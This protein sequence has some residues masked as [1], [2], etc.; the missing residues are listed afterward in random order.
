MSAKTET[1]E[2]YEVVIGLEIHVELLTKSKMFCGCRVSFGAEPNTNVCP[3]CLGMPGSLPVVNKK[4]VEYTIKAGLALNSSIALKNQFHRKNYFYPDMPKDYQISQ[5][6]MPLCVGGYLDVDVDG[7]M[8]R[9]GITR[10]HLEED[11]GKM[12]HQSKTGRIADADYSLV[13]FN[14]AGTPLM[15]IVSEPDMRSPE[16]AR[17]FMRKLHQLIVSIGVS[18]CNMEEGSMR[19]DANISLRRR[20]E[21][22]LGVKSEIKNMNSFR[23]LQRALE[24]EVKRQKNLIDSGEKVLQETR[25]WNAG[26]NITTSMRSKEEAHD[27]R[28]FPDPDLV[29]MEL[30]SAWVES[31]RAGLPELP[32]AR[33]DR[34]IKE[35]GLSPYDAGFM[36]SSTE[37]GN[38]FEESVK[39]LAEPKAISN[40]MMGELAAHLNASAKSIEESPVSPSQ[41]TDLIKLVRGGVI[42]GKAAKEVFEEMF[43]SGKDPKIIV[44]EKGMKQISDES[45]IAGLIDKVL[46]ANPGAVEEFKTGKKQAIGFLVGQVMKASR[47]QANPKLVNEILQK[48]LQ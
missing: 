31:I 15:E 36:T 23:A 41:L 44:E 45:E 6:D 33:R 14:R 26:K 29:P 22:A 18:D 2:K 13:D 11:T 7:E 4:A 42:S 28:Y 8:H 24:Y 19:C 35:F 39:L 38:Y 17:A 43:A 40:W 32:A 10:V 20:G 46:G 5:Y 27:Y 1:A 47:G 3:V 25:H 9:I 34:L 16:E 12:L 37:T 30:D 48:K 21:E